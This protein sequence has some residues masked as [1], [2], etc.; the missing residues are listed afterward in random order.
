MAELVIYLIDQG[1]TF[2]EAMQLVGLSGDGY[3]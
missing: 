1:Y 2:K 3:E